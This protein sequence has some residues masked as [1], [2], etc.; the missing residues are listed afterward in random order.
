MKC[1]RIVMFFAF[2]A[3]AGACGCAASDSA[4]TAS[5]DED[6]TGNLPRGWR[7]EGTK[8]V[9]PVATWQVKADPTAPS[10]PNVLA[11]SATNHD[12]SGTYNICWTDALRFK[13]GEI[14]I[15]FKAIGGEEDQGGGL[16]WRARDA[17]NYYICRAN[18]LEGN[19]RLYIVEDGS[20]KQLATAKVDVAADRWHE[21]RV[22]HSGTHIVCWLD[23]VKHLEADDAEFAEAGGVGAWTKADAVTSFD[24]LRVQE[25]VPAVPPK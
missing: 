24:D 2:L 23:G 10:K 11:L 4:S 14:E 5:F 3:L 9:G 13:D 6:T 18:P 25:A 7:A 19:F 17:N 15:K 8:Q 22:E 20:R 1:H 16:A 21:L 12:S